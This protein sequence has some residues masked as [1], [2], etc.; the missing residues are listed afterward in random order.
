MKSEIVTISLATLAAV[1]LSA[2]GSTNPTGALAARADVGAGVRGTVL[3]GAIAR[4]GE[5]S[6]ATDVQVAVKLHD[7]QVFVARVDRAHRPAT[8]TTVKLIAAGNDVRI[9]N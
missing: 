7:G 1:A 4:H 5:A 8:G 3:R 6:D 9:V 2:C